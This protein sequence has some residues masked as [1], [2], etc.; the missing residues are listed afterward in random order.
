MLD[1]FYINGEEIPR[2]ECKAA[3][4]LERIISLGKTEAVVIN[5]AK[6]AING[7]KWKWF[8]SYKKYKLE[9]KSWMQRK[10]AFEPSESQLAFEEAEP[11]EPIRPETM[12]INQML[13]PYYKERR[14]KEYPSV[15]DFADAF[16]K[17]QSG[18]KSHM[19]L[20]VSSCLK[21]K[22]KYPKT[23]N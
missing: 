20:Y 18:D 5:F 13:A 15:E 7:A 3:A 11:V 17:F 8:D 9:I 6:L 21:V 4:D 2:P 1:D 23:G 12:T 22:D 10:E 19:E 14:K 16:V